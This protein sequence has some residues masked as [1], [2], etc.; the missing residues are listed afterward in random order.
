MC[1]K[2][3]HGISL[4]FTSFPLQVEVAGL[5]GRSERRRPQTILPIE[6]SGGDSVM[7]VMCETL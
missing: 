5:L 3:G 1:Q 7:Q 4:P 2:K 6:I